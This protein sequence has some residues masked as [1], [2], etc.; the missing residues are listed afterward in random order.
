VF[1]WDDATVDRIAR[2]GV[3]P[4]EV[5]ELIDDLRL[6][7]HRWQ[8]PVLIGLFGVP[9]SGKSEIAHRLADCLPLVLLTT[10]AIRLRYG[11][12][13]GP[14]THAV[15]YEAAKILLRQRIG[16]VWDGLH[17]ARAARD[18]FR[19]FAE[20]QHATC[21]LIYATA[22]DQIVQQRLDARLAH[23]DETAAVGKFVITP[24]HFQRIVSYLEPPLA[25]E[26]VV[27]ID[28]TAGSID[29][30]I[31]ALVADLQSFVV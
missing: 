31:G 10:D 9:C 28:T 11:L 20:E 27:T 2:L 17:L 7:P 6:S 25:K 29:R 14:A 24:E 16:I 1:D 22:S 13:S 30:Q 23:P 4:D 5:A 19:S 12:P 8:Q 15:M 21:I 18:R 26:D 3:R